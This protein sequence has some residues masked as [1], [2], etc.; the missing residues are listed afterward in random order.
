LSS[1]ALCSCEARITSK[2]AMSSSNDYDK[3]TLQQEQDQQQTGLRR[4][5]DIVP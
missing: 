5:L 3:F 1:A 4:T 2:K